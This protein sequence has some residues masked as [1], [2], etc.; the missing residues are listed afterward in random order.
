MSIFNAFNTRTHRLNLLAHILKNKGFLGI[1]FFV[2][3]V[4]VGLIYYGGPLFRV[5]GLDYYE[6]LFV[7]L[8]ALTV[9]PVDSLRKIFLRLKGEIGGV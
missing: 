9:I 7:L 1:M 3:G 5:T 6:F 4:Q 2:A 8:L